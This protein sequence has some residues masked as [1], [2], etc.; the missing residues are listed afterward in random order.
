VDLLLDTDQE[1]IAD[2]IRGLLDAISPPSRLRV[3]P[4]AGP[5]T[6]PELWKLAA[7]QGWFGLDL[8]ADVGGAGLGLAEQVLLFRELGR[9]LTAGP[10]LGTAIAAHVTASTGHTELLDRIVRGE[11]RVG[12]CLLT[13]GTRLDDLTGRRLLTYDADDADA[14]V[15]VTPAGSAL[16]A[17]DDV[18]VLSR[19][20][21]IDPA[22]RWAELEVSAAP[23][24]ILPDERYGALDFGRVLVSAMLSGIA[25]ETARQSAEYAKV[26]VQFGVPIGSFQA[27]QHRCSEQAIRAAAAADLVTLAALTL[28]SA[29]PN[30]RL[31]AASAS[32][33]TA[34]YAIENCGDNIQNHGGIGYT[35]EH[36]AHLFL[37]R[38]HVL[39]LTL[40][41]SREKC[42]AV[43]DAPLRRSS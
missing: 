28:A 41:G 4:A 21:C 17:A 35:Y 26:R 14:Y 9:H 43:L 5:V 1:L 15:C 3:L 29:Q 22:S 36:D 32:L 2:S 20:T 27:V 30:G 6:D 18:S 34:D 37:K 10:F 38:S 39:A 11:L 31:L 23:A 12:F 13:T 8:P 33:V 7:E 19:R 40:E 24:L 42:E 25:G 16:L